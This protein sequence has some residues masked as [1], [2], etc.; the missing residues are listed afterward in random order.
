MNNP[1]IYIFFRIRFSHICLTH[2]NTFELQLT[3]QLLAAGLR[4][5]T[6]QLSLPHVTGNL[7]KV[8][9]FSASPRRATARLL[10]F[11]IAGGDT[12]MLFGVLFGVVKGQRHQFYTFK[13]EVLLQK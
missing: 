7:H 10:Q 9:S 3:A 5:R 4:H 2:L 11:L 12:R 1:F 8:E 13:K 6:K